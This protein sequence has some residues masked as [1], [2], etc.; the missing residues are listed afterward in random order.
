MKVERPFL[1]ACGETRNHEMLTNMQVLLVQAPLPSV[2]VRVCVCVCVC[3]CVHVHICMCVP[4]VCVC[5]FVCVR[6]CVCA[7]THICG[8]V[9]TVLYCCVCVCVHVHAQLY[10]YSDFA[11][12]IQAPR[13]QCQE[14]TKCNTEPKLQ[15]PRGHETYTCATTNP[16]LGIF[17]TGKQMNHKTCL[18]ILMIVCFLLLC[19]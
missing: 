16:E 13:I 7:R 19:F 2:C 6:V 5:V 8:W 4:S 11:E 10:K 9:S 17:W 3:V 1:V 12:V 15:Q 18:E 14:C